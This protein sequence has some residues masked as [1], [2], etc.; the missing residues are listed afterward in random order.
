MQYPPSLPLA[1]SVN[2][3]NLNVAK[4]GL[5]HTF[6]FGLSVQLQDYQQYSPKMIQFDFPK[7]TSEVGKCA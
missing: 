2:R 6:F 5:K 7:K 3:D 4:V 1:A